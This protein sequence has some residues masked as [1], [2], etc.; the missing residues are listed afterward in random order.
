MGLL[1]SKGKISKPIG[2]QH[3]RTKARTF[4]L[5]SYL[6]SPLVMTGEYVFKHVYVYDMIF[7][8]PN[9]DDTWLV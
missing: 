2:L 1:L 3:H 7:F 9:N 6:T 5:S 4:L 8:T